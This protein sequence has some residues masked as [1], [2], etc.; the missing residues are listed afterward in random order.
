MCCRSLCKVGQHGCTNS[1]TTTEMCVASHCP[2]NI[3]NLHAPQSGGRTLLGLVGRWVFKP[4]VWVLHNDIVQSLTEICALHFWVLCWCQRKLAHRCTYTQSVKRCQLWQHYTHPCCISR[5]FQ[6]RLNNA[7]ACVIDTCRHCG[8]AET[9][10]SQQVQ[11][12]SITG[13]SA[14]T[15]QQCWPC[16]CNVQYAMC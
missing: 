4:A 7:L 6:Q 2:V 8:A 13:A 16:C 10:R 14:S 1:S 9:L 11:S 12:V 5:F 3:P 15:M